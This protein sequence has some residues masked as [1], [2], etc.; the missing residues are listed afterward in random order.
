MPQ[1]ARS[2]GGPSRLGPSP[3]G[4]QN[5][6]TEPWTLVHV[7]TLMLAICA[8]VAAG[9][10]LPVLWSPPQGFPPTLRDIASRLPP[11][12]DAR[13]PCLITYT[14]EGSHF[15]CRGKPGYHCIY[16]GDGKR[17]EIPTPPLVT[18]EVFARFPAELRGSTLYR[19]Y[20]RQ[21]QT[22]YWAPQPLMIL[23]E[24]RAY[25]AGSKTR[26]ETAIDS[27][28]ETVRHM[29]T[30]TTYAKVLYD[31]AKE[32][33]GYDMTELREFCRWNLA[34]CR[35]IQGFKSEVEFD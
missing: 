11:D 35:E 20:L 29:E 32:V 33:E 1:V 23:D 5:A 18:E 4:P 17:W 27:R 28:A 14:H 22:E 2:G 15:L 13:E 31:L 26:Q 30:F 12:T 34:Q 6:N 10:E 21:G 7:R 19:T 9:E 3:Y 8:S 16:I 24:W 25:T